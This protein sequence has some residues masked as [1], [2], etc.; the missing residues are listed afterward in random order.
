MGS[1]PPADSRALRSVALALLE[2]QMGHFVVDAS[3]TGGAEKD[4]MLTEASA[5]IARRVRS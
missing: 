2:D 5:A 4:A 1:P 3:R